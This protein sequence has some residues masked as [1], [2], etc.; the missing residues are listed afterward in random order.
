LKTSNGSDPRFAGRVVI[1]SPHLDDA[2]MSLGATIAKAV[3]SGTRIEVLTVFAYK[4][5]SSEPAGPWDTSCGYQTEGQAADSRRAEDRQACLALGAEPHWMSFGAEPYQRGASNDEIWS[6]VDSATRGADLVLL[7]GYPLE[8]PDHA[9]LTQ[10]LLTRGLSCGA[11][12]LYAEQPYSF[13]HRSKP[14]GPA[15]VRALQAVAD[16]PLVWT[17]VNASRAHRRTKLE[18]VRA[19]RSQLRHL[20]L[21][22]SGIGFFRLRYL[23]WHEAARGGEAVAWLS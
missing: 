22:E 15:P 9:E 5:A 8:H 23:L 13:D 2:V 20:G 18:A 6:A 21:G 11:I 12:G 10:L 14:P 4:P 1:V 7:P 17:R 16:K 3:Q 19:Y